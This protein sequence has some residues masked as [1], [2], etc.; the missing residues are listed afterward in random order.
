MNDRN[1]KFN[2]L[3]IGFLLAA[4]LTPETRSLLDSRRLALV[5][6]GAFLVNVARGGLVDMNALLA[7]LHTGRLTAALD[8]TDPLEP[9]PN[10]HEL[11]QLPNVLLTPH[12]AAGGIETRRA[13]GLIAVEE[14]VR[15]FNGEQLQNQVTRDMLAT[16][17]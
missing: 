6:D 16:M 2:G 3:V 10:Q 13:I 9:L 5:P 1:D 15:F 4:G 8:V 14:L 11:R 17:T 7:E 12:I